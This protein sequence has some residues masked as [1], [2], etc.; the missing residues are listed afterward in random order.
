MYQKEALWM[1]FNVREPV[2]LK[3]VYNGANVLTGQPDVPLLMKIK[4]S[5]IWPP[6]CL[7]VYPSS[8]RLPRERRDVS[9]KGL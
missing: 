8:S 4:K 7:K 3:C 9:A 1:D 2:A 5:H 6:P